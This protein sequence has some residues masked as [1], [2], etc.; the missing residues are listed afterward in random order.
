MFFYY[1]PLSFLLLKG[2]HG[3]F[4]IRGDVSARCAHEGET[5]IKES[6]HVL[7]RKKRKRLFTLSRPGVK[8]TVAAF[9]GLPVLGANH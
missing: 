4:N 6:A 8:P 9:A 5:G 1:P 2:R 7:T 3:I